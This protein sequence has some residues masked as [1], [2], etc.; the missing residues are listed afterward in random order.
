MRPI[1]P[2]ISKLPLMGER[3]SQLN[4]TCCT[5]KSGYM[6]VCTD[7]QWAISTLKHYY[8]L[9][10]PAAVSKLLHVFTLFIWQ[11]AM[12]LLT[13]LNYRLWYRHVTNESYSSYDKD[14]LSRNTALF[15]I[16]LKFEFPSLCGKLRA[17]FCM[18]MNFVFVHTWLP[19][20]VHTYTYCWVD[21]FRLLK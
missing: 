17:G 2:C 8:A 5:G 14:L 18:C 4:P 13:E 3:I 12:F 7:H 9:A 16:V 11:Q 21:C 10:Q 19:W 15:C 20:G 6:V 1:F